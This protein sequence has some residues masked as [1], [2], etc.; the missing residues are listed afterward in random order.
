M[1]VSARMAVWL[2]K[3]PCGVGKSLLAAYLKYVVL[4]RWVAKSGGSM[5][6]QHRRRIHWCVLSL[7]TTVAVVDVFAGTAG[8]E[9]YSYDA[10]GRI[11]TVNRPDGTRASY[12]YDKAGNRLS[13]STGADVASPSVP[14]NLLAAAPSSTQVNLSWTASI[15]TGG[16]GL[17]GYMITRNGSLF[18]TTTTTAT[19]YGD[20]GRSGTTLYSYTVAAYDVAGNTSAYSSATSVTTPDTI[21]PS[22]VVGL[23]ATPVSSSQINLSWTAATDTGGSGLGSY[24]VFRGG[25]Q[26]AVVTAPTTTFSNTGLSANTSYAFTVQAVDK[27]GNKAVVSATVSAAT[28][29]NIV[30]PGSLGGYS[31]THG[32]L[33]LTWGAASGGTAPYTY[34]VENCAGTGCANF[35]QVATFTATGGTVTG[36]FPGINSFRV[37]AKDATGAYSGYSAVYTTTVSQ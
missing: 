27:S 29:S 1:V 12:A 34:Y 17:K 2:I 26:V 13:A 22:Q 18:A 21:A 7:L 36:L 25:I 10:L 23:T 15:D 32:V 35:V 9:S 6:R 24:L 5:E 20:S 28:S 14:T 33:I 30:P 37:R 31:P 19:T 16:S 4:R 3:K 8:T 11:V